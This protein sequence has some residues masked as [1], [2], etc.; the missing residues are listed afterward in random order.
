MTD[1]SPAEASQDRKPLSPS[2]VNAMV[3][4]LLEP[5]LNRLW[6]EGEI[7]NW[8]VAGSGHAYF[9]LKDRDSM[10][11]CIAWRST[12]A[13]GRDRFRDGDQVEVRGGISVYQKRGQYSLIADSIKPVGAGLLWQKFLELKEKLEREGLFDPAR[14]RPIPR[15]PRCVGIVTSPTG[16]AVRDMLHVLE[17]RAPGLSVWIYPAKVQGAGA[18]EE[19]ARG[20]QALGASGE[21]D[22]VIVARG[23]GSMEDL[24]EFNDER[25]ARAIAACPVPVISGVGHEVDFTIA[26]FVADMR[27]PTPSA[28]AEVVSEDHLGT[29]AR[30]RELAGRVERVI[31]RRLADARGRTRAAASSY[32]LRQPES[33]LREAQQRTDDALRRAD[34]TVDRRLGDGRSRLMAALAGMRGH[35][36]G[37]VL[38][39]GYAIVR[40]GRDGKVVVKPGQVR[41]GEALETEFAQGT[42]RSVVIDDQPDLFIEG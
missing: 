13:K 39:K 17:R 27:A 29:L 3:G 40:R 26:D 16:A 33:L 11:E 10:L 37:L 5:A 22:V 14:K 38:K 36:P 7:S 35:D 21:V 18:A 42:I 1:L 6:V 4:G 24:W 23:G 12:L 31:D 34:E 15:L 20:V 8:K 9:A 25:L 2:A 30:V 41:Q 28:A 19:I 32:A